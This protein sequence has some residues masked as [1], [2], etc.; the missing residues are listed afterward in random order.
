MFE[1]AN[2]IKVPQQICLQEN[3]INDMLV[4]EGR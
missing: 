4:S 1:N 2:L 3:R